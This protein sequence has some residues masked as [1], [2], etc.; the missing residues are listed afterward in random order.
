MVFIKYC[1]FSRSFASNGLLLLVV[2]EMFKRI[3]ID[4]IDSFVR[5]SWSTTCK[6]GLQGIGEKG[7]FNEQPVVE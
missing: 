6:D 3:M 1:A 5:M 4:L 2:Q 7:N